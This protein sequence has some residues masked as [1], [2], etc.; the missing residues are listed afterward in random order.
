M[1]GKMYDLNIVTILRGNFICI[2]VDQYIRDI[3]L[4]FEKRLTIKSQQEKCSV[5]A[6]CNEP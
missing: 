1:P 2:L 6:S 5:N 3:V 4:T